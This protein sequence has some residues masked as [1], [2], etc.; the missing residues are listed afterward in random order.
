MVMQLASSS[1]VS[2]KFTQLSRWAL[3]CAVG[4]ALVCASFASSATTT[5]TSVKHHRKAAASAH[6]A[7]RARHVAMVS[8]KTVTTVTRTTVRVADIPSQSVGYASG[9][10]A[11]DDPLLLRS[12]AALVLDQDT[13]EV[14]YSKNSE[15][16][17]PI[18]SLSKL[19]TALV[20]SE[21]NQSLDEPILI[22][23]D[24]IDT[25]K[26]TH[27]RLTPG[28]QLPRGVMLHLALMSS[29]NRA[30]NALGRNYP[31][32]LAAFV[33]AMNAKAKELG[34]M[35]TH[36]VE[37]TGLSSQ[38]KSSARDLAV[39]VN[40]AHQVPLLREYSTTPSL[41]V[42]LGR[43]NVQFHTTDRLVAN[44][45]WD[46]GL[47]KTGFI[48]EAGQCLVMQAQM[49]GRKLI[50][51]LLDSAGKYSRIADAERIRKWVTANHMA[52]AATATARATVAAS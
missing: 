27:S 23:N 25:E 11:I 6:A 5:A 38:N 49:A 26:G 44:P 36:Y 42:E 20:I 45:T 31:G 33:P 24:D 16:V 7:P 34:M 14:L 22:T 4:G 15:A 39:L 8:R 50:M 32:G 17:L 3:S 2:R 51:V 10:H 46:I 29:E 9:L 48:N 28:T 52:P 19:M 40:A 18:A 41:D 12:G 37:P 13:H 47:Q 30:A 43:R 21:A 35:D 1:S